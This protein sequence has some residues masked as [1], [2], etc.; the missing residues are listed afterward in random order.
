[1][2]AALTGYLAEEL[3]EA[4]FEGEAEDIQALIEAGADV[5]SVFL[6]ETPLWLAVCRGF[7]EGVILLLQAGADPWRPV[8]ADRSAGA[9]AM[10]GPLTDLFAHLPG[11]PDQDPDL[12]RRQAA[13]DALVA[14]Y[15][16]E[17]G[18]FGPVGDGYALVA[19]IDEDDAIRRLG[20]D[21]G[22]CPL[23][24]QGQYEEAAFEVN[25]ST[26][27]IRPG[28]FWLGRPPRGTGVAIYARVGFDPGDGRLWAP[29]G[30]SGVA[31]AVADYLT[32]DTKVA[33]W[34]DGHSVRA[35]QS[36]GDMDERTTP[37]EWL[38]RFYDRAEG[39]PGTLARAL[40]FATLVTGIELEVGW[41]LQAP[42]RLV[43]LPERT[44][45]G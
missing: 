43:V 29:M 41:L 44:T 4:C 30:S 40:A 17:L 10:T 12:Q 21:P 26:G 36:L 9:I 5:E 45:S 27:V 37:E 19:G 25:G 22:I 11:A 8:V 28:T 33:V 6:D 13:V 39:S 42:K 7:R 16:D 34:R 3:S 20:V 23:V 14:R 15:D 35:F 32:A 24:D 1:M 2:G 31:V 38:C 18:P